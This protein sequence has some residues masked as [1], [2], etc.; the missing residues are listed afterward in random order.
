MEDNT[1]YNGFSLSELVVVIAISG[2]ILG[3]SIPTL[4]TALHKVRVDKAATQIAWDLKHAQSAAI[5]SRAIC[6][7]SFNEGGTYTVVLQTN[8]TKTLIAVDMPGSPGH[9]GRYPGIEFLRNED[10]DPGTYED[11]ITF[12]GDSINFKPTRKVNIGSIYLM[13]KSDFVD[14]RKDRW[15]KITVSIAGRIRIYRYNNGWQ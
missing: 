9:P 8:P 11:P 12:A 6:A 5:T 7:V 4:F 2:I 14:G 15:R 3:V 10:G 13:P 1:Q